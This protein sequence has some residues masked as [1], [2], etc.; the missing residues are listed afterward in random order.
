MIDTK[1]AVGRILFTTSFYRHGHFRRV[2][3]ITKVTPKTVGYLNKHGGETRSSA[4]SVT[5]VC[6]T[7]EEAARLEA[8][9]TRARAAVNDLVRRF[10]FEARALTNQIEV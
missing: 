6:D 5:A 1:P 8:F 2:G 3:R 10:Q 4:L 9:D 7:E